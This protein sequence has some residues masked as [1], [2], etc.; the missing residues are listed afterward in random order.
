ML[1]VVAGG[2]RYLAGFGLF[3]LTIGAIGRHGAAAIT[4]IIGFALVITPLEPRIPGG[5]GKH[6]HAYLPTAPG[7]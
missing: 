7:P 1:Q 3:A 5:A 2:G 4:G 6:L